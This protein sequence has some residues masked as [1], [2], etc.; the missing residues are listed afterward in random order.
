MWDEGHLKSTSNLVLYFTFSVVRLKVFLRLGRFF[1][2]FLN[3]CAQRD[4][5]AA[6]GSWKER[7][8]HHVARLKI[9]VYHAKNHEHKKSDDSHDIDHYNEREGNE[10]PSQSLL[11][12]HF[13]I[14]P[15][16]DSS[17]FVALSSFFLVELQLSPEG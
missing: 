4:D 13:N 12:V 10:H 14:P 6:E 3:G 2:F 11:L 15:P 9:E 8:I 7:Q 1:I 5:D 17:F 16:S